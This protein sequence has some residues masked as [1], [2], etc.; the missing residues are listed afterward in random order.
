MPLYVTV[1]GGVLR[2]KVPLESRDV[3]AGGVCFETAHD[4]SLHAEARVVIAPFG[5]LGDT[6]VIRGRVAR[7]EPDSAATRS[8]VGVEFT[9]FVNVTQESLVRHVERWQAE[10]EERGEE[11]G[12]SRVDSA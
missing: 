8:R 7:V 4:V 1:E 9:G 6:I 10:A 12:A 3:S 2:K 5:D 11:A